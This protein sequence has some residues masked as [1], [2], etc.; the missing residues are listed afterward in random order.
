VSSYNALNIDLNRRFSGGLQVRAVYTFSKSLDDG[1]TLATAV[2]ANAPAFVMY[3]GNTRLDWGLS[4]F[5]V[6]N[7]G[8]INS[9]YQLPFGRGRRFA[10]SFTNWKNSL[11][12]GWSL[13]SI[14]TLQSGFPFTPQLGFNPTNNGDS[15]NPI[16][17]SWNATF[18]GPVI[19]GS[20]NEYFNPEAFVVP[21][22]GTYGNVGR[23]VLQGPGLVTLDASLLKDF[24]LSER[25]KLQFRSEFF[26]VLNHANF[27]TPN[28]IVFTAAGAGPSSTAGVISATSTTSR[29]IQFGLKLLW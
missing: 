22:A 20:P 8:V 19:L 23:D 2:G 26:N 6:R 27:S 14:V 7:L 24:V 10:N 12:G 21:A 28:P 9:V 1:G 17:P 29:Q 15:R 18:N 16:R 25:M 11:V 13:A 5:D 4:T 3:P